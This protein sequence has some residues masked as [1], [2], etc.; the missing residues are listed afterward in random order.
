MRAY[1]LIVFIV[2]LETVVIIGK[3]F[4]NSFES[5]FEIEDES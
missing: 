3:G 4:M 2:R 5:S 1:I